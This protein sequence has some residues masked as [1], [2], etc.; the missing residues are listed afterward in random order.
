MKG[1]P[2]NKLTQILADAQA[3]TPGAENLLFNT[4]YGDLESIAARHL[5]ERYG[6]DL[7]GATLEPSAL[8]NE[9]YLRLI[10][11]RKTYDNR[12][13]FFAI[14]TRV[15]L[16]VLIDYERGKASAKRGGGHLRVTLSTGDGLV[17]PDDGSLDAFA[18]ALEQLRANDERA[19]DVAALRS[20]WGFGM[21]EIAETLDLSLRTTE[22]TWKFARAWLEDAL[23]GDES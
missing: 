23:V 14:A 17:A 10:R 7:A 8:V 18:D 1:R 4:I 3:G 22:R 2:E 5:R 9:S 13:Q 15:I 12:G 16:R 20:V 6:H 11:Q 21:A 19:A